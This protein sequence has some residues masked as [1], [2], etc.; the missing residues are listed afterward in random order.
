MLSEISTAK[1][2]PLLHL[3]EVIRAAD[4]DILLLSRF[5][6]DY[7]NLALTAFA[8]F[9]A[10]GGGPHYPHLLSPP[11]NRGMIADLDLDGDGRPGGPRDLQ[12][13]GRFSGDGAMALLSRYPLHLRQDQSGFLWQDLPEHSGGAA[14]RAGQRLSS[15]GHWVVD[16]AHPRAGRITLLIHGAGYARFTGEARNRDEVRFWQHWLQAPEGQDSAGPLLYIGHPAREPGDTAALIG[17]PFAPGCE[18]AGGVAILTSA[19]WTRPLCTEGAEDLPQ[20]RFAA[21]ILIAETA[22]NLP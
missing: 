3:R 1:A 14:V 12:G 17:P 19:Q 2:P 22:L 4:P 11:Q 13:W 5:D 7:Q 18:T 10:E 21:R 9:L 15:S 16:L 20:T 6:H 8:A